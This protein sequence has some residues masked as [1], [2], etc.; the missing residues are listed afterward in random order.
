MADESTAVATTEKA[1]VPALVQ[2]PSVELTAEDVAL[3]TIKLGQFMSDHVQEDRV[4][5]GSIFAATGADDP[6][7]V[8]LWEQ[9]SSDLVKFHV[10]ALR[11]GK[12]VSE[13]GELVLFQYDDPNAPPD[14][15]VT[16][17]YFVALP[18]VDSEM[19]YKLLLTRTGKPAA[20]QINTVV[21][22]NLAAG[23]AA[24]TLAFTLDCVQRENKKG[25]FFVPR[26]KQVEADEKEVAIAE[27]LLPMVAQEANAPTETPSDEPAI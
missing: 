21:A 27:G 3:P 13:G 5:A 17:N 7:P 12:S 23:R 10:L 11:K 4:P 26:V 25:K 16:Y 19:P 18:D 9:E 24:H 2:T 8:V 1:A 15:W 20:Q 14:A 22:K 6:D